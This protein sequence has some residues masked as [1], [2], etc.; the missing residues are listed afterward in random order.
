MNI[1]AF[2]DLPISD[3][4]NYNIDSLLNFL[5]NTNIEEWFYSIKTQKII[6]QFKMDYVWI[7]KFEK[8]DI[9][10]LIK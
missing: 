4:E 1:F 10:K 5:N 2:T 6:N 8:F 3:I 9:K 7:S